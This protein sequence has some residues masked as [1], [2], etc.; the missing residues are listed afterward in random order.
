[1]FSVSQFGGLA[2]PSAVLALVYLVH[3]WYKDM[4]DTGTG[5]RVS[6]LD[7]VKPMTSL[8]RWFA[9]YLQG[10]RQICTFK[11]RSQSARV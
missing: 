7:F 11:I 6:L 2:G 10:E 9:T 5:V 8:I 3:N 4:D 1:M